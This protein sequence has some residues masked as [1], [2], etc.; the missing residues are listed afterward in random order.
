M[1]L[2][3]DSLNLVRCQLAQEESSTTL[4]GPTLAP[5]GRKRGSHAEAERKNRNYNVQTMKGEALNPEC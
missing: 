2:A 5:P 3:K 1:G 4:A